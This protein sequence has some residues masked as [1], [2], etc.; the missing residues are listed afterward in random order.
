MMKNPTLKLTKEFEIPQLGFGT[1]NLK[2]PQA[3]QAIAHA[4][5]TGYRHLDSADIYGTHPNIAEAIPASTIPREEIFITTKLWSNTLSAKR[6]GPAVDRFLKELGTEYIDLLLIHWPGN[7]PVAETLG[8][9]DAARQAG[10]VRTLGVSNFD[11]ALMQAAL[12]T[13]VPVVNNQIEY[14]INHRP[15]DVVSFCFSRQVTVTAYSPLETGRAAQEN[16][17]AELAKKHHSSREEVLLNWLMNKG[18]IVI[19][20]SADPSHIDTN[21]HALAWNLPDEDSQRLD[22]A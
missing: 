6:V 18:M 3:T 12:D 14:N 1:W 15:D 21:W 5:G 17:L 7:T 4:L 11:V 16:L 13:G 22:A 9:M 20:R 10:K 19:P 2:D 8:A